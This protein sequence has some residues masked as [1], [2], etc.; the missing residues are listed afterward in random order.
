MQK[1]PK[2]VERLV[3]MSENGYRDLVSSEDGKNLYWTTDIAAELPIK[4]SDTG[5]ASIAPTTQPRMMME[6]VKKNENNPMWM[7]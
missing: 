5:N 3:Q 7:V 6:T 1:Q 2:G 4:M